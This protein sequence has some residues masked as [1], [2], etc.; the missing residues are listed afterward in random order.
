[1][2]KLNPKTPVYIKVNPQGDIIKIARG[3]NIV[4]AETDGG[5]EGWID[6][7]HD[8]LVRFSQGIASKRF[9]LVNGNLLVKTTHEI[10]NGKLVMKP[11]D[12]R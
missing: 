10:R 1:M 11:K 9:K 2:G 8:P 5:R 4:F 7:R 6:I 12:K 3:S